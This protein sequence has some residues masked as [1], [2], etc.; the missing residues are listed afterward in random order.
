M[1]RECRSGTDLEILEG[2]TQPEKFGKLCVR[3]CV[4]VGG[5]GGICAQQDVFAVFYFKKCFK[6]CPYRDRELFS[7]RNGLEKRCWM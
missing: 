6:S 1:I 4:F 5:G 7:K 3:A 2:R